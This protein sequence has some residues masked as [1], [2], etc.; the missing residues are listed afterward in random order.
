MKRLGVASPKVKSSKPDK[1]LPKKGEEDDDSTEEIESKKKQ[2]GPREAGTGK[3]KKQSNPDDNSTAPNKRRKKETANEE[4]GKGNMKKTKTQNKKMNNTSVHV[5]SDEEEKGNMNIPRNQKKK[6]TKNTSVDVSCDEEEKELDQPV[7]KHMRGNRYPE[8]EQ[9]K[10]TFGW[11]HWHPKKGRYILQDVNKGGGQRGLYIANE[12]VVEEL[13]EVGV[14]FF[15][16]GGHSPL[17]RKEQMDFILTDTSGQDVKEI[18][19]VETVETVN[20]L[21]LLSRM[22]SHR[23]HVYLQSKRKVITA[24]SACASN[25]DDAQAVKEK[26]VSRLTTQEIIVSSSDEE[27]R[28]NKERTTPMYPP[29]Q[30]YGKTQMSTLADDDD[31][32]YMNTPKRRQRQTDQLKESVSEL[33]KSSIQLDDENLA[34]L[35]DL[36]TTWDTNPVQEDDEPS[37]TQNSEAE[38]TPSNE[39]DEEREDDKLTHPKEVTE[40][41]KNNSPCHSGSDSEKE[42]G[43]S[44]YCDDRGQGPH[45][46]TITLHR[47][48]VYSELNELMENG[49]LTATTEGVEVKMINQMGMEEE[50]TDTGGVFR[51]AINEYWLTFMNSCSGNE[52][53][54]P[55]SAPCRNEY[56]RLSAMV[57][58]LGYRLEKYVPPRIP[59]TFLNSC[60]DRDVTKSKLRRDLRRMMPRQDNSLLDSI[61]RGEFEDWAGEEMLDFCST[62]NVAIIAGPHNW[63][64]ILDKVAHDVIIA[65]RAFIITEWK[66]VFNNHRQDLLDLPD[67]R[68][69]TG[70]IIGK[71]LVPAEAMTDREGKVMKMMRDC[72]RSANECMLRNF[73]RF[74]TGFDIICVDKIT[75]QFY[76]PY[77]DYTKRPVAHTCSATLELPST[78]RSEEDTT[79]EFNNLFKCNAAFEFDFL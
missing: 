5:S 22:T 16:P 69:I 73:L 71:L 39:N 25:A 48:M 4:A 3:S 19:K 26:P 17:G 36:E 7:Q 2:T 70:S 6:R 24:S 47:G 34:I 56:F 52:L 28:K 10:V 50:A 1:K 20:D 72:L 65:S 40:T 68:I 67:T 14:H 42:I 30:K 44:Q 32:P 43:F 75:V 61:M 38:E 77:S 63:E 29:S 9:K 23:V 51:C 64:G 41:T 55:K 53:Q 11:K 79:K 49:T 33:H 62:Y 31:L 60:L 57:L 8:K 76:T 46:V 74:A 27:E 54:L 35:K 58:V 12:F 15:F 78:Y 66:S 37:T 21:Y 18:G 13:L 45:T 59:S